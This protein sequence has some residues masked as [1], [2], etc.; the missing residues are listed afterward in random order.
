MS[1]VS[2]IIS[3]AHIIQ[4]LYFQYTRMYLQV[5]I[6]VMKCHADFRIFIFVL[7]LI[8]VVMQQMK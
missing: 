8:S 5:D 7:P 3:Q 6:F 4:V 1:K 2:T